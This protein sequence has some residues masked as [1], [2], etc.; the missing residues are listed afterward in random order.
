MYPISPAHQVLD[1]VEKVT[2]S[3][4]P[5]SIYQRPLCHSEY[6]N[7]LLLLEGESLLLFDDHHPERLSDTNGHSQAA[8]CK[9]VNEIFD[10]IHEHCVKQL[11]AFI[12]YFN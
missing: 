7:D 8:R 11:Q 12:L 6:E 4:V 2:F 9:V 10:D 5:F 1:S 3:D